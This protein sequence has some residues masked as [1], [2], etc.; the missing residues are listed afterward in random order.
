M[1]K[2]DGERLTYF[3]EH[4]DSIHFMHKGDAITFS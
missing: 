4:A 3:I 2:S 1:G